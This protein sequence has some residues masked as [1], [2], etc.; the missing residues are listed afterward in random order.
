M[1]RRRRRFEVFGSVAL[2][3]AFSQLA[4]NAQGGADARAKLVGSWRVVSFELEFQDGGERLL[5]FGTHPNGYL[6]LGPDGRMMF[7][8]EAAGRKVPRNEED[9]SSAYGTLAAYTGR[10]RVEGDKWITRV[11]GAWNVEWVGTDQERFFTLK[12]NRLTVLARWNRNPLY[13][14]RMTRGRLVF[15]REN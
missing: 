10:Y 4:A 7:Y 2:W 9:R 1:L 15:E 13:A 11:D 3:L 6:V 14:G 5:P 8:V 12:G